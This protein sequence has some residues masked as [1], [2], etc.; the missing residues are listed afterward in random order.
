M[1]NARHLDATSVL[2]LLQLHEYLRTSKRHLL[3][4]GIN[5]D[6]ERV[7]R[8]SGAFDRI[9]AENVFPAEANLTMST[10][11]ALLRASYLLQQDGS[12]SK[13]DVRIFYDKKRESA[14]DPGASKARSVETDGPGMYDI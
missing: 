4:S 13:A 6:V 10:R 14:A 5:P 3:I 1:K 2:S 9:G 11:R 7:L 8:S 12:T